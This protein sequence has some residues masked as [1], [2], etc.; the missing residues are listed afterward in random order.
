MANGVRWGSSFISSLYRYPIDPALVVEEI[1]LPPLLG[2]VTFVIKHVSIYVWH[3]SP[4]PSAYLSTL[5]QSHTVLLTKLCNRCWHPV[6]EILP[7]C[8]SF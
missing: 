7:L 5:H 6:E 4:T 3:L 2:D 8:S 1:V